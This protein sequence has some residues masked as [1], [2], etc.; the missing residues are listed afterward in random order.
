MIRNKVAHGRATWRAQVC[1]SF[2]QRGD[3]FQRQNKEMTRH[4]CE[5]PQASV[6][7]MDRA[8]MK[9]LIHAEESKAF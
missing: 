9:W 2:Q 8:E 6:Y 4:F 5:R 3:R 1:L 7:T